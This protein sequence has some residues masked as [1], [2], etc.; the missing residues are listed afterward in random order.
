MDPDLKYPDFKDPRSCIELDAGIDCTQ[1]DSRMQARV[2]KPGVFWLME[3]PDLF[4][5]RT[6]RFENSF[7][8][9]LFLILRLPGAHL[10]ISI[11]L[12]E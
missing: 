1:R 12:N 9:I 6:S 7:T 8:E 4:A 3:S 5:K 11:Y 2:R 10:N